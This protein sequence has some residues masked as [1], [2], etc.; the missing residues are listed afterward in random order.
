[1]LSVGSMLI[2]CICTKCKHEG[3]A[4]LSSSNIWA[5]VECPSCGKYAFSKKMFSP[6][7]K[8]VTFRTI[9]SKGKDHE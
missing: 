1:M 5:T 8:E 7:I 3:D 4:W 9:P 2:H 6:K